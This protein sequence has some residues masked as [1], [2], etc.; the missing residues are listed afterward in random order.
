[1]RVPRLRRDFAVASR[2]GV[3]R[4]GVGLLAPGSWKGVVVSWAPNARTGAPACLLTASRTQGCNCCRLGSI[5]T[6]TF[7]IL[8]HDFYIA[9]TMFARV[10]AVLFAALF[11]AATVQANEFHKPNVVELTNKN[12]EEKVRSCASAPG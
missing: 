7:Y 10:L 3:R 8:L 2:W 11:A 5:C 4:G 12:F 6:L 1:M 9:D